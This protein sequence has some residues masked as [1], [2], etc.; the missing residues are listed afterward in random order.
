MIVLD[1]NVLSETMRLRPDG[2][3]LAWLNDLRPGQVFVSAVTQAEMLLGVALLSAGRRREK[4][5]SQVAALFADDFANR[6]LPF[7]SSAA[8]HYAQIVSARRKIG[9]PVTTEDAQI[10]AIACSRNFQLATRNVTDFTGIEAL[11][12][13]NPWAVV[14]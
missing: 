9:R 3:V 8:A 6:C 12:I 7:D 14:T 11:K 13:V 5:A 1:T 4:L 10:A 2:N